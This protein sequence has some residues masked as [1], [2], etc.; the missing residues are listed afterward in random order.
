[1]EK[2]VK[3]RDQLLK[4]VLGIA[5]L[6]GIYFS[7]QQTFPPIL[8]NS[9]RAV[10]ELYIWV[11]IISMFA[12]FVNIYMT[13]KRDV[14]FIYPDLV[15]LITTI[16]ALFLAQTYSMLP[17][18]FWGIIVAFIQY[19]DWKNHHTDDGQT[20]LKRIDK[21]AIMIL[22]LGVVIAFV[23]IGFL[24]LIGHEGQGLLSGAFTTGT[25]LIASFLL[26][27]RYFMAEYLFFLLNVLMLTTYLISG[28]FT[29]MIIPMV[30]FANNIIFLVFN[31]VSDY[32]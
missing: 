31:R 26:A 2:R 3:L 28:Q 25:G 11:S 30:Y 21:Q 10:Q 16:I 29:L 19:Y 24:M 23:I 14:K 12:G 20:Q 17:M 18:S 15:N 22:I 7:F 5:L 32:E 13:T 1:M 9:G 4:I 8:N 6:I 27:K